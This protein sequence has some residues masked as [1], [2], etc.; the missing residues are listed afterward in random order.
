MDHLLQLVPIAFII[1]ITVCILIMLFSKVPCELVETCDHFTVKLNEKLIAIFCLNETSSELIELKLL[2]PNQCLK[3]NSWS[4]KQSLMLFNSLHEC[5]YNSTFLC[6]PARI[7]ANTD[8]K[9]SCAFVQDVDFIKF[10][11]NKSRFLSN[12][13]LNTNL[14]IYPHDGYHIHLYLKSL[15]QHKSELYK[16]SRI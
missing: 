4:R 15:L 14:F 7:K 8:E 6:N 13:I 3:I 9:F 1:F 10:C 5:F 11:F 2:E 12:I 16:K